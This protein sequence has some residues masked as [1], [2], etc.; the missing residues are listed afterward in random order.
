MGDD[1]QAIRKLR[2]ITERSL[3]IGA[4]VEAVPESMV[5]DK[6]L[7]GQRRTDVERDRGRTVQP[8]IRKRRTLAAAALL[9]SRSS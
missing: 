4:V 9:L 6:K 1:G 5:F 2:L 3:D 7:G 8:H